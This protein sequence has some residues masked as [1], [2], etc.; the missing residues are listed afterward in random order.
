MSDNNKSGF[1]KDDYML[2][3]K[4]NKETNDFI[5]PICHCLFIKATELKTCGHIYCKHCIEPWSKQ[6]KFCPVCKKEF[7]GFSMH[8]SKFVD[9][10]IGKINVE[11]NK[12]DWK[13]VYTDYLRH[14]NESDIINRCDNMLVC[15]ILCD[16]IVKSD[17]MKEHKIHECSYREI[18]C[19]LCQQKIRLAEKITH[20]ETL[21]DEVNIVCCNEICEFSGKRKDHEMHLRS[22]EYQKIK[23][24]FSYMGCTE[25]FERKMRNNHMEL[26]TKKHLEYTLLLLNETTKENKL[27]IEDN[28]RVYIVANDWKSI[29]DRQGLILD[30]YDNNRHDDIEED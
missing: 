22:C 12:C 6:S 21:C 15:C 25:I 23:C 10:F 26:Y 30:H 2:D 18:R 9:R 16:S 7:H 17:Q 11:C 14:V 3:L 28:K 4:N 19:E 5:C 29:C 13:G 27:L 1:I 24:S 8:E 20:L